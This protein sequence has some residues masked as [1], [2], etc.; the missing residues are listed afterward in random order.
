MARIMGDLPSSTEKR[1]IYDFAVRSLPDY[2]YVI[3]G[4]LRY[5]TMERPDPVILD[6]IVRIVRNAADPLQET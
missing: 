1:V 4:K 6:E 5:R 3:F 2:I